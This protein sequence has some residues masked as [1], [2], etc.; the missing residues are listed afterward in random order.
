MGLNTNFLSKKQFSG[1]AV[2]STVGHVIGSGISGLFGGS[3]GAP[4]EQAQQQPAAQQ[5][6]APNQWGDQK[7][8]ANCAADAKAFTDCLDATKGDYNS[9]SYY[10]EQLVRFVFVTHTYI[11]FLFSLSHNPSIYKSGNM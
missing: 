11:L 1:V 3:G 7:G 2:G 4:A 5:M 9:C 10:L 6:T 8:T